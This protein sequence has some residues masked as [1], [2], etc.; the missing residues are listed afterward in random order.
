MENELIR[1]HI[2]VTGRVQGVG[3]RAFTAHSAGYIGAAGWVRNVGL[4]S[5][6]VLAEGTRQQVEKLVSVVKT[7][8]RSS[9]VDEIRVEEEPASG[10]FLEFEIRSS[11]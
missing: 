9:R 10:E 4:D 7:G 8:P 1:V 11:R 3:F 2:F 5:V 6:E